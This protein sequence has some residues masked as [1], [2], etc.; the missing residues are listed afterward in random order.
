MNVG[1][2]YG[3]VAR[4]SL[5][6]HLLKRCKD[7]GVK[8]LAG[9]VV[10]IDAA[11][12]GVSGRLICRNGTEI[13]SRL[14]TLASGA[15]AGKFL[16]FED[17][18]PPVAAQTAYGIEAVVEGYGDVFDESTML[19]MDY[20]RH[21]TGLYDGQALEVMKDAHPLGFDGLWGTSDEVPSF[22]YAMPLD[23]GRV[24]LEETALV[25][26]PELPFKVLKRRLERRLKALGVEV[27]EVEDEEWS[28]IPVGGPLPVR[29]QPVTAFGAA[30]NMVHPATGYSLARSMREAPELA[31]GIA[32][33][34]EDETATMGQLSGEVWDVL[35]NAEKQR[36]AAFHV[37]GMELLAKLSPKSMNEF[38]QAF[39]GMPSYYWQNFLGA[40]LT[41]VELLVFA[42]IFFVKASNGIRLALMSHLFGNNSALYMINKYIEPIKRS[43]S[44]K[45]GQ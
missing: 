24:F 2:A 44:S 40:S 11:M 15:V 38:F 36:Q 35:W 32:K 25:A 31:A 21:H 7:A 30:A 3:R 1:R 28:Y 9:E 19:F 29:E 34:L 6:S 18:A 39:F 13:R 23:N 4:T 5:R 42:A 8:Y 33:A 12:D 43:L 27:V 45:D 14:I 20:R 22:L 17:N 26:R 41:S 37:F 16:K 10:E